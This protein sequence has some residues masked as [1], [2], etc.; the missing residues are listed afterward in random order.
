MQKIREKIIMK[1]RSPFAHSTLVLGIMTAMGTTVAGQA[2]QLEEV[3][4]TAQKKTESLQDT[5]VAVTALS[6][7]ELQTFS[8]QSSQDLMQVVPSLQVSTQTA[9]DGGGSAT[10]F[11]RGMG[12]QRSGN[13]S[14]PAV[15]LYIDD[16]YYPTIQGAMFQ[17]VDFEQVEVLRGPQGTLFGRNSIGGAIRYS[18]V[19]P[20]EEFGGRLQLNAGEY[21]RLDVVGAV[22]IPVTDRFK[23]RLSGGRLDRD[24]F[25]DYQQRSGKA[26]AQE[27]SLIKLQA[28]Y[29]PTDTLTLDFS[30][31]YLED[32]LDGFAYTVPNVNASAVF[33]FVYNLSAPPAQRYTGDYASDC[34]FCQ[35]GDYGSQANGQERE[36]FSKNE[37]QSI[38]F[39]ATWDVSDRVTLKSLTGYF[40]VASDSFT[41]IDG[42]PWQVLDRVNTQEIESFSEELQLTYDNGDNFHLTGGLYYFESER[43]TQILSALFAVPLGVSVRAYDK[44]ETTSIAAFLQGSYDITQDLNIIVGYRVNRDEKD[45]AIESGAVAVGSDSD[46]WNSN[47]FNAKLSYHLT[48]DIMA[49]GSVSE[50]FRGGGYNPA[51]IPASGGERAF[52]TF[53]PEDLLSYEAGLR[54]T[55][56]D[57][58]LRLNPTVFLMEW[59]NV[60]VQRVIGAD[61]QLQNVGDAELKGGELEL[62][63]LP[64][65]SLLVYANAAY[66]D[67]RY[68]DVYQEDPNAV[69]RDSPFQR[70][71]Q[72][73]FAAG[74]TYTLHLGT[75]ATIDTTV[76]Y[77]HQDEQW[78]TPTNSDRLL[79]PSYDIWNARMSYISPDQSVEVALFVTNLTDE[80]YAVGGV[81]YS[82]QTAGPQHYDIGRPREWGA[83]LTYNF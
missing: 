11:L 38:N 56:L 21:N 58:A 22:N 51:T 20:G 15:S 75:G 77:N 70:A 23:L 65:D 83:S 14:E 41:D 78:S 71:P 42:S 26:G 37:T 81:D 64:T 45:I 10:Y 25:V 35:Y 49:Y 62:Q 66:L 29:E 43:D 40:D 47:V 73:T 31:D 59:D 54:M 5:P 79:L 32:E 80:E 6:S 61:I 82:V 4:V 9:G 8:I 36:E 74:A 68:T 12:Q 30:A 76:S 46:S 53:D 2:A 24:G 27:T 7:D 17:L 44:L 69:D 28:R 13:G 16:I 3:M 19:K 48:P 72:W 18:S 1:T 52:T 63:Y 57:G 50:G 34:F 55:L 60:Q 33:P 39:I 67:A